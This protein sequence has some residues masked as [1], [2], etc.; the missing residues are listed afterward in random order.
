MLWRF[1]SGGFHGVF[2]GLISSD[3]AARSRC[4]LCRCLARSEVLQDMRE[5]EY[6]ALWDVIDCVGDCC[7]TS[8]RFLR[9]GLF[10]RSGAHDFVLKQPAVPTSVQETTPCCW[11]LRVSRPAR[12]C[13][14]VYC[15]R[16][17]LRSW[18]HHGDEAALFCSELVCS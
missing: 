6:L 4:L 14:R 13:N 7:P 15:V 5:G 8:Q 17:A 10:S 11:T 3:A 1:Y 16:V 2:L 18:R 12:P 9:A